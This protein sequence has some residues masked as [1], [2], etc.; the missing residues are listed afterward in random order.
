MLRLFKIIESTQVCEEIKEDFS[1]YSYNN[2]PYFCYQNQA[3]KTS[4]Q[5]L[6]KLY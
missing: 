5:K 3:T 2:F 4:L 1:A 6:W